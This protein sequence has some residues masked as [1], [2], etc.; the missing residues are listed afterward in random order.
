MGRSAATHRSTPRVRE[1]RK[2]YR[3]HEESL[4]LETPAS[5]LIAPAQLDKLQV[6]TSNYLIEASPSAPRAGGDF[7]QLAVPVINASIDA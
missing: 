7:V 3:I 5:A 2:V 4:C 1:L 6:P